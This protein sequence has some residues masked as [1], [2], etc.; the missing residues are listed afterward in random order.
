MLEDTNTPVPQSND[1]PE[2]VPP[3]TETEF[4]ETLED[5][6]AIKDLPVWKGADKINEGRGE[7]PPLT[8][9]AF[10]PDHQEQIKARASELTSYSP[11]AAI[12][13][14]ISEKLNREAINLRVRSTSDDASHYVREHCALEYELVEAEKETRAIFSQLEAK[15]TVVDPATGKLIETDDYKIDGEKRTALLLK[16]SELWGRS[17]ALAER[18]GPKRLEEAKRKDWAEYTEVHKRTWELSE[19][20]RRAHKMVQDDRLNSQAAARARHLKGGN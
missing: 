20:D 19:I 11:D 16:A 15:R 13:Q 3:L 14:A 18:E 6:D 10:G 17:K 5:F 12:A 2:F 7:A 4:Y 1:N 8:L 9:A